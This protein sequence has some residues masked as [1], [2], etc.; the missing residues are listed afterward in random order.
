MTRI[1]KRNSLTTTILA[2]NVVKVTKV[3]IQDYLTVVQPHGQSK[4]FR[5]TFV[6]FRNV[7]VFY[8][9]ATKVTGP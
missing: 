4:S 8:V 3:P 1:D 5:T 9:T 2:A 7:F 6:R